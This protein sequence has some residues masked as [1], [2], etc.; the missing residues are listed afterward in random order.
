MLQP[1]AEDW[2]GC[3]TEV[4]FDFLGLH[5]LGLRARETLDVGKGSTLGKKLFLTG[6][7]KS[8]ARKPNTLLEDIAPHWET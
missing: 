8:A 6:L 1:M 7:R 2:A 5:V 3:R 4:A